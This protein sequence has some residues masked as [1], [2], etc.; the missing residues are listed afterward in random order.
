M[1]FES[2]SN[3]EFQR[4]FCCLNN[5]I[6]FSSFF[7][8]KNHLFLRVQKIQFIL[9]QTLF[10]KIKMS[11]FMNC[12]S[13]FNRQ[14]YLIVLT[15]FID[16]NWCYHEILLTFEHVTSFHTKTKLAKIMQ[17]IIARHKLKE[18][19]YV[20][21]NDNVENNLTMHE[22]LML[23][24]RTRMFNNIDTNVRDSERISCL[25][26]VI[27]LVLKD[28]FDKIRINSKNEN[29]R[30]SWDDKQDRAIMKKKKREYRTF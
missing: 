29:F 1:S 28:L 25:A 18:R 11:L 26:H 22:E 16:E 15:Y 9:L 4:T 6:T 12:W 30:T 24:L 5:I 17:D 8:I 27:Q 3:V 21:T 23:L 13:F 2:V 14:K 7:I 10:E 19:I 20:V